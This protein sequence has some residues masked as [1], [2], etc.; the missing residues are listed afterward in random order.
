NVITRPR[1]LIHLID[2]FLE[3]DAAGPST[4]AHQ[5]RCLT[6]RKC[7]PTCPSG[8]EYHKLLD[9]GRAALETR[10]KRSPGEKLLRNGLRSLLPNPR[11]C[12]ILLGTGRFLKPVLAARLA[13]K[14]PRQIAP[15]GERWG[16]RIV[17]RMRRLVG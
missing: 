16:L 11:V 5:N 13:S 3:H 6:S 1:G 4:Q 12:K 14:L 15:A 9:I 2:R 17:G 10:V 8:V 7:E